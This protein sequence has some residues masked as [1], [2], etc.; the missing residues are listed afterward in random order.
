MVWIFQLICT[1]GGIILF[2]CFL[3]SNWVKIRSFMLIFWWAHWLGALGGHPSLAQFYFDHR[4][5]A[6]IC[7]TAENNYNCDTW[8]GHYQGADCW[9][10]FTSLVPILWKHF[11]SNR[12]THQNIICILRIS[13]MTTCIVLITFVLSPRVRCLGRSCWLMIMLNVFCILV[14]SPVFNF[15][16]NFY[17]LC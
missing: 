10:S 3:L 2:Y 11:F 14:P 5:A 16:D 15:L 1:F 7:Y 13:P 6:A 9:W 8:G 12:T 17:R 4:V